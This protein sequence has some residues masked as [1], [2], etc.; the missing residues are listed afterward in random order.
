MTG[1]QRPATSPDEVALYASVPENSEVIGIVKAS[2]DSGWTEQQ[3]LDYAVAELKKQA[4]KIGANGIVIS[5]TGKS[6][7]GFVMM[8]GVAVP[9]E[10][11]YVTGTAIYVPI[12]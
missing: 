6:T 12:E 3:S 7:D 1:T 8:Y 2:S 10:A 11:Q 4:A 5:S 9:D